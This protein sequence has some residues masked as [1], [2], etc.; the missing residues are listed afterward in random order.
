MPGRVE[1]AEA[2]T[3]GVG[4]Q[5]DPVQA[6]GDAQ[7]LDVTD[8]P[9][10]AVARGVLG[11]RGA[12]GASQVQQDQPVPCR[13][14]AE[15]AEVRRRLHRATGQAD[16]RRSGSPGPV[17]QPGPVRGAE[18]VLAGSVVRRHQGAVDP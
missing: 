3:A 1:Q 16:Q 11:G 7:R 18:R 8:E 10:A 15:V 17:D 4:E 2:R 9:V 5:V 13:Q 14:P 6:Q 12:T